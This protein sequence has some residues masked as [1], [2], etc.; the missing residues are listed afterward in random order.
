[1]QRGGAIMHSP[2]WIVWEHVG[3]LRD[4]CG[5]PVGRGVGPVARRVDEAREVREASGAAARAARWRGGPIGRVCALA[6][7]PT[8]GVCNGRSRLHRT[9]TYFEQRQHGAV[10]AVGNG[11]TVRTVAR[12]H[13]VSGGATAV[14]A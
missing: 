2:R 10:T 13:D 8:R 6:T 9:V 1:M 11:V 14:R 12:G 5:V 4:A 3:Y 7:H